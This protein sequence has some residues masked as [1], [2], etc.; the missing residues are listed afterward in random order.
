MNTPP[1]RTWGREDCE[2]ALAGPASWPAANASGARA[3]AMRPTRIDMG[4]LYTIVYVIRVCAEPWF[5]ELP[6]G[7][8]DRFVSSV[9]G[10]D[11]VVVGRD[12]PAFSRLGR[13]GKRVRRQK[14]LPHTSL[15]IWNSYFMTM[16]AS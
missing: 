2:S 5:H 13:A 1:R 11:M 9:T 4:Y 14:C 12:L 3:S 6:G 16:I 8:D 10:V 7:T 15:P